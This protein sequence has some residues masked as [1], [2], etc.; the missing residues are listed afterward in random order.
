MWSRVLLSTGVF[1][2]VLVAACQASAPPAMQ[3]EPAALRTATAGPAQPLRMAVAVGSPTPT[4][5]LSG[6]YAT[7]VRAQL[8][9]M[10]RAFGRLDQQLSIAQKAPMRMADDDWLN[11]TRTVLEDLL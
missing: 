9:T 6:D 2:A 5:A 1:G 4:P 8:E 3:P 7:L 10:Q 11:Q